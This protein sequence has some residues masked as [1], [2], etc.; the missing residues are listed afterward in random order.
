VS[1]YYTLITA[2]PW[3]PDFEQ[4]KQMPLSRIAL[5][6]RLT[7]LDSFDQQQLSLVEAL[8]FPDNA[9]LQ[10]NTD[11]QL[12]TLWRQQ[13][14]KVVSD[15]LRQRINFSHELMAII[16]AFR[17]RAA[18]M[19]NPEL[20]HGLG[21]WLPRIRKHWFEPGFGLEEFFP[22]LRKI[23]NAQA[24][25]NP[26]LLEQALNQLLWRDLVRTE[27]EAHFSFE[28]VVCFVLRWNIAARHLQQNGDKALQQF[29]LT[30][31]HLLKQSGLS[32]QLEQGVK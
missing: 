30:T 28:S 32:Q 20:F 14:D 24:K 7:M 17:S 3:L 31:G 18:G 5:D 16:A 6:Q 25:E 9:Y 29:N 10:G 11:Q 22:P 12:V 23:T 4:C 27:R 15:I 21:R 8:Y 2:L 19:E 26:A 13:A 1:S